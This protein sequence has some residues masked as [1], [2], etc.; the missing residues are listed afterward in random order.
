MLSIVILAGGLATRIRPLTSDIPKAL[1]PIC[2]KPFIDWQLEHIA[3]NKGE[4]VII[5][6]G[7]LGLMI[8]KHVG[9]GS[10][11]G[12]DVTYS[13]DGE[14][15]L[16]TGGAVEKVAQCHVPLYMP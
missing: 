2:D 12:L 4:R 15:L 1:V 6:T 14:K 5:A 10:K 9:D 3:A 7:D 11:F 13:H 8:E 16:G